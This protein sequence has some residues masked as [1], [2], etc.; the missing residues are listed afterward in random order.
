M[1]SKLTICLIYMCCF[2]RVQAQEKTTAPI[3]NP[4]YLNQVYYIGD[5]NKLLSL[6]KE[7]ATMKTKTKLGGF[8]GSSSSYVMEG[9]SSPVQFG[10]SKPS[11]AVKTEGMMMDPSNV[12]KLY[13]FE[14]KNNTRESMI[15]NSGFR[16]K[17]SSN[18]QG[19]ISF[20]IKKT[21]TGVFVLS[22]EEP[23]E[24]GEYGFMN[25]MTPTV[26]G[27]EYSLPVFAFAVH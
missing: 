9:S 5:S 24:P 13:R 15:S 12:L 1:F 8:G 20:T 18:N 22:P 21:S 4:E 19:G 17:N 27:R 25:M 3:P 11:F 2:I 10:N 14:K 26:K 23:L 16:G 6:E 7:K